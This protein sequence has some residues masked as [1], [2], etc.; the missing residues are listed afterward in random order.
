[1]TWRL[2]PRFKP[3]RQTPGVIPKCHPL[4]E[5]NAVKMFSVLARTFRNSYSQLFWLVFCPQTG[6]ILRT[7][8]LKSK[9]QRRAALSRWTAAQRGVS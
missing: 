1:M 3:D 4:G 5:A 7:Q 2:L 9:P 8:N 6:Q